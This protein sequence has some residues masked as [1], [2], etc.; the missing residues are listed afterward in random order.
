MTDDAGNPLIV[1]LEPPAKL[2]LRFQAL[3]SKGFRTSWLTKIEEK[4]L[5]P[6]GVAVTTK[7]Q[8]VVRGGEMCL[9]RPEREEPEQGGE[10]EDGEDVD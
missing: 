6:R 9:T 7:V 2:A 10:G 4:M 3:V 5:C 8:H 1:Y